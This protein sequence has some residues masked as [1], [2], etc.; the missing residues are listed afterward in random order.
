[1]RDVQRAT[2]SERERFRRYDSAEKMV[3]MYRD[4]RSSDAAQKVHRRLRDLGLPTL[5]DV[6]G[7]SSNSLAIPGS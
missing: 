4:D 3:Q 1:M 7:E 6:R 5:P 2:E